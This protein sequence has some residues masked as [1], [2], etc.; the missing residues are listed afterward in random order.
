MVVRLLVVFRPR[1]P[2]P[3]IAVFF[4]RRT[5]RCLPPPH[6]PQSC[7]ARTQLAEL[8]RLYE[9]DKTLQSYALLSRVQEEL[10]VATPLGGCAVEGWGHPIIPDVP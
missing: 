4:E 8:V 2:V 6:P 3:G 7:Q 5:P 10:Q 9:E 1:I